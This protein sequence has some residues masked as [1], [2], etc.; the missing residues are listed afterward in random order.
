M[1]I[2]PEE[3]IALPINGE[4]QITKN[5]KGICQDWCK[6]EMINVILNVNGKV[7]EIDIFYGQKRPIG[8][9]LHELWPQLPLWRIC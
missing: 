6:Y 5:N 7:E 4:P 3:F 2:L 8:F 1:T 9:E